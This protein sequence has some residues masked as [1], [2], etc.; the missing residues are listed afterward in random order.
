MDEVGAEVELTLSSF[1]N[2]SHRKHRAGPPA[3]VAEP[4]E[5]VCHNV[6]PPLSYSCLKILSCSEITHTHVFYN[7]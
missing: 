6:I 2:N 3:C 4:A 7:Q 5:A 1:D